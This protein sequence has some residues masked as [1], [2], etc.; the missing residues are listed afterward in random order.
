[1]LTDGRVGCTAVDTTT[2]AAGTTTGDAS[3]SVEPCPAASK[4]RGRRGDVPSDRVPLGMRRMMAFAR[5]KPGRGTLAGGA[6]TDHTAHAE[7]QNTNDYSVQGAMPTTTTAARGPRTKYTSRVALC[8]TTLAT[9]GE[10]TSCS[11]W[12]GRQGWRLLNVGNGNNCRN[13]EQPAQGEGPCPH[14]RVHPAVTV[15]YCCCTSDIHGADDVTASRFAVVVQSLNA[16][17]LG[18]EEQKADYTPLVDVVDIPVGE[19]SNDAAAAPEKMV[20]YL[21]LFRFATRGDKLLMVVAGA[22]SMAAGVVQV[23]SQWCCAGGCVAA[24]AVLRWATS[25]G[26][27]CAPAFIVLPVCMCLCRWRCVCCAGGQWGVRGWRPGLS[28]GCRGCHA[29]CECSGGPSRVG[30]AVVMPAP[31]W[32][33]SWLYHGMTYAVKAAGAAPAWVWSRCGAWMWCWVFVDKCHFRP[34]LVCRCVHSPCSRCTLHAC[35]TR[36]MT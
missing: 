20:K 10:R 2:D 36:L 18:D 8:G 35:W 32:V 14:R 17:L 22:S 19:P 30:A 29:E 26:A 3:S 33:P 34:L 27:A 5:S 4:A 1:M 11:A 28:S 7:A 12:E 31:H 9:A 6:H 23:L 16:P 25:S 15:P 21:D 13:E 24:C